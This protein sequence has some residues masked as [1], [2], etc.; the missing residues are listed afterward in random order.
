MRILVITSSIIQC[1]T[2]QHT[3]NLADK[4][5]DTINQFEKRLVVTDSQNKPS[6]DWNKYGIDAEVIQSD[7]LFLTLSK[8]SKIYNNYVSFVLMHRCDTALI[9]RYLDTKYST[10]IC[11]LD[12]NSETYKY[13]YMKISEGNPSSGLTLHSI[14]DAVYK[15]RDLTK[16]FKN[17]FGFKVYELP[18]INIH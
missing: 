9:Q 3:L 18:G 14:S 10:K 8:I 6:K 16:E 4:I 2:D 5:R 13:R 17:S 15:Y 12:I 11:F 1:L 7:D